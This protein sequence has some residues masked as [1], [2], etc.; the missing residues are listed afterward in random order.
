[1]AQPK[2]GPAPQ[3]SFLEASREIQDNLQKHIAKYDQLADSA[4]SSE[5]EDEA[6]TEEMLAKVLGGYSSSITSAGDRDLGSTARAALRTA[7]QSLSC[8]ICI[9]T[10]KKTD[11]IWS[12]A[13]CHVSFHITCIQKWAKDSIF[14]QRQQQEEE[15]GPSARPSVAGL[16]WSCPKCRYVPFRPVY[17]TDICLSIPIT[18]MSEKKNLVEGWSVILFHFHLPIIFFRLYR[19]KFFLMYFHRTL[20]S[21]FL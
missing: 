11:P 9:E 15:S 4:D 8:L 19:N 3:R 12:C 7:L 13:T 18:L 20:T 5:D 1:M 14:L 2:A 21:S 6:I 17:S 10:V 16:N